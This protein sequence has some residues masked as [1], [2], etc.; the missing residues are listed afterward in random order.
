MQSSLTRRSFLRRA[1]LASAAVSAAYAMPCPNILSAAAKGDKLRC[2]VIGCGGRGMSH[3]D[4]ALGENMVAM[5]DADEKRQA[6][7]RKAADKKGV[8]G[9]KIE[10]FYDYRRMFDKLGQKIDAVF[11][12]TPNHHHALPSMIAMQL[13]KGIYCEKPL[14]HTVA[15]ARQLSE[16]AR[17][18]KTPTQMGNQGHCEEGYRRL[19]E[20]VW[21]GV[22]GP[23]TETHTWCDRSNGGSGPRPPAEKAPAGMHWDEW[24][25]PAPYRDFHKDLHPHEWHGW[26][27]FGNGSLG[28][29]ACHE[30]DGVYWALKLEH[31][32][33]VEAEA[34]SGG[35]NERYP[36]GT[37]IRWDFPE[38]GDMPALKA[39]WYDGYQGAP[40]AEGKKKRG[41]GPKREHYLPPLLLELM[42][43]YPDEKFDS[44]GT[45]YVG[46]K[47]V[48]YTGCYGN[49][50]HIMPKAKMKDLPAVPKSLPR[51]G[52]IARDFLRACRAH[53]SDTAA[54]FEYSAR[55]TEFILLGNLA[56]HAG[57][58][59]IVEWDGPNMKVTNLPELNAWVKTEYRK[60]WHAG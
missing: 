60:G 42:K 11:V 44:C 6:A 48:L 41:K 43:Q 38:R 29:L 59:K 10:T 1:S 4:T 21:A 15:E 20:F 17:K 7:V 14:C 28:N 57:R 36:T 25:G 31:P 55:L 16:M 3:V 24:I 23:I 8:N 19:C 56:Q 33:S 2:V 27:D 9:D 47:G 22:V 52:N 18:Y 37:R 53:S 46:K 54:N 12:A 58:N 35:S 30:M 51:P 45:L 32:L 50:M 49:D 40:G 39:Y 13:G 26:Y 34:I 5:V